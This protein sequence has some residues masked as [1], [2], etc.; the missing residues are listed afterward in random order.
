[1]VLLLPFLFRVIKRTAYY[2]DFS[3]YK[4]TRTHWKDFAESNDLTFRRGSVIRSAQV[5]G[6]YYGN[7]LKLTILY[8]GYF[9][10]TTTVLQ[11]STSRGNGDNRPGQ[12]RNIP[13]DKIIDILSLLD[14]ESLS[15]SRQKSKIFASSCG[16]IWRYEQPF[17]E[18]DE[19]YLQ[20]TF[21]LLSDMVKVYPLL[22]DRVIENLSLLHT[23]AINRNHVFQPT[24]KQLLKDFALRTKTQLG[25]KYSK[26]MCSRC[27]A[28]YTVHQI[29][30]S[31][32]ESI[33][34]Y[35]CRICNQGQE[36]ILRPE[37]I[38]AVL[39][40]D[41]KDIPQEDNVLRVDWSSRS[42]L[43]DFDAVEIVHVTDEE[44]ERFAVQIGN[45][46]DEFR[47]KRYRDMK[48]VV[49]KSCELSANSIRILDSIFALENNSEIARR[50]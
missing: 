10:K 29:P 20:S 36:Y 12:D 7:D 26:L 1:M 3:A 30:L 19:E 39:D 11:L 23:V 24:S 33:D 18:V 41:F 25:D 21:D 28:N 9:A 48:C 6:D 40:S 50:I 32:W 16:E 38:I 5:I 49:G 4:A 8:R 27:L 22:L 14:N 2:Y 31:R 37:K 46:T 47:Q 34:F 15:S 45:D 13:S 43:F 35:G 44:I 42:G 17:V